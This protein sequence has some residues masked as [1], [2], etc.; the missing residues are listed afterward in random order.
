MNGL[1]FYVAGQLVKTGNANF[2]DVMQAIF[3]LMLG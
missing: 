2:G 3:T 1:T